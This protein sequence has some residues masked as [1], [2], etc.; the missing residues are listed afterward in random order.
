MKNTYFSSKKNR[1]KNIC[2]P[3]QQ[4]KLTF[5]HILQHDLSFS[6]LLLEGLLPSPRPISTNSCVDLMPELKGSRLGLALACPERE[7]WVFC[8]D[9]GSGENQASKIL[10]GASEQRLG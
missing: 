4:N 5:V 1:K 7:L 8:F 6:S 2:I 9:I 10:R 3:T